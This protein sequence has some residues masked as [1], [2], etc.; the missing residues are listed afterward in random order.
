MG[1]GE[2]DTIAQHCLRHG[3][4]RSLPRDPH[5][6]HPLRDPRYK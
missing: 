1:G 6:D 3:E 5:P 2:H 4:E